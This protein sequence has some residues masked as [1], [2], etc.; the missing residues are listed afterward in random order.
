MNRTVDAY[1]SISINNLKLKFNHAPLYETVNLRICPDQKS[2]LSEVRFRF[3][4][5]LLD[6][7]QIKTHLLGLST[8]KV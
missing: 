4:H 7:Q 3:K 6:V 5:K 8:F 1:R 2:G